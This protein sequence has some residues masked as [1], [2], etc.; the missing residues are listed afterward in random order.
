MNGKLPRC[1]VCQHRRGVRRMYYKTYKDKITDKKKV[2]DH[3]CHVAD[4]AGPGSCHD[5]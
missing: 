1:K 3:T 2:C 5:V 4:R